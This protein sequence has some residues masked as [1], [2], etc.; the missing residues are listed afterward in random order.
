M[1]V[2]CCCLV[3]KSCMTLLQSHELQPARFLCPW[4]SPGKNTGAGCHFLHQAI[5]LTQGLN[6]HLLHW[7]ADSLSLSHQGGLAPG[8]FQKTSVVVMFIPQTTTWGIVHDTLQ[9][10][11]LSPCNWG[12]SYKSSAVDCGCGCLTKSPIIQ[13]LRKCYIERSKDFHCDYNFFGERFSGARQ[14]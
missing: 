6:L 7:Q 12:M 9:S 4:N 2:C 1:W 8:K 10:G 3:A 14:K 5:F 13:G 11:L